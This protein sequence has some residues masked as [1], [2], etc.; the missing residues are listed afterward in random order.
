M[1]RRY[2]ARYGPKGRNNVNNKWSSQESGGGG[3]SGGGGHDMTDGSDINIRINNN[4]NSRGQRQIRLTGG[5]DDGGGGSGGGGQQRFGGQMRRGGGGRDSGGDRGD[6]SFA[7][8]S[9]PQFRG[10]G[11]G[12]NRWNSNRGGSGGG[13][14]R[15]G[16]SGGNYQSSGD[17]NQNYDDPDSQWFRIHIPHGNKMDRQQ[18][19]QLIVDGTQLTFTPYNFRMENGGAVFFV[20]GVD[21]ADSL[22][23]FSRKLTAPSG[24]KLIILTNR[25]A[26]PPTPIDDELVNILKQVMSVRYSPDTRVMDLQ[27]LRDDIHLKQLGLYVSLARPNVFN[28]IVQIIIDN[29]P[30]IVAL[31]LRDNKLSSLEPLVKLGTSCDSLKALDLSANQIRNVTELDHIKA[32]ELIELALEGNPVCETFEDQAVY[33]SCIRSRFAKLVKMDNEELPQA[34]GFDVKET[35]NLPEIRESYLPDTNKQFIFGFFE[36]YYNIYD[37]ED[38]QPLLEA[39]HDQAVF[40]FSISR[41]NAS[42]HQFIQKLIQDS[43][44]L[45]HVKDV[46]QRNKLLKTGKINIV[47]TLCEMPMTRHVPDSF[48]IDV[49]FATQT[50]MIV[51]VNGVYH[52]LIKRQQPLRAFCRTFY[53]VPHGSGFVIVNDML[54]LT[55]ATVQQ[56]QKYGKTAQN[57]SNNSSTNLQKSSGSGGSVYDVIMSPSAGKWGANSGIGAGVSRL[58]ITPTAT[59]SIVATPSP[60]AAATITPIKEQ[61]LVQFMNATQMNRSFAVQCLEENGFDLNTAYTVFERL[62]A[63]NMIPSQAFSR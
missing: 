36:A 54:L 20:L 48:T 63:E 26:I 29:T 12:G 35:A 31:N 19:L 4:N 14:G 30:E 49:A 11:G 21:T 27:K 60:T 55:N 52:E 8:W 53:I 1:S 23:A 32:L 15:R 2:R 44:N 45:M 3:G 33:I 39:Y 5:R 17:R 37:A 22:R 61:V 50:V 46:S 59:S 25:S 51:V 47:S 6:R 41:L 40:S 7:N 57:N 42:S 34:I 56:I 24:H 58:A 10:G 38:R 43:R 16:G 18:L 62:K 28:Q 9:K 13:G